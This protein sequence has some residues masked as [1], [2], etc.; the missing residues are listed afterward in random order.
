LVIDYRWRSDEGREMSG[1]VKDMR[2]R[3]RR[4]KQIRVETGLGDGVGKGES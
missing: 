2:G 3:E 4:A 1:C